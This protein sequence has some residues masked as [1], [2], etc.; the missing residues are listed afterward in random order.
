M[1]RELIQDNCTP[2]IRLGMLA[3]SCY[4]YRLDGRIMFVLIP[5]EPL[6]HPALQ[7]YPTRSSRLTS[8]MPP[9]NWFTEATPN[10]HIGN[11]TRLQSRII[12]NQALFPIHSASVSACLMEP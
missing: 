6:A 7:W 9:L 12:T 1:R 2:I 8:S 5:L 11:R 10:C 4:V 3:C